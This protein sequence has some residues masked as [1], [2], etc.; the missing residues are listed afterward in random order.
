MMKPSSAPAAVPVSR[1]RPR[2]SEPPPVD[3]SDMNPLMAAHHGD[4]TSS[5]SARKVASM[6]E[7]AATTPCRVR[8]GSSPSSA[9]SRP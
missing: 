7:Q 2:R 1:S 5:R 9:S 6:T 8:T 3:I 4:S